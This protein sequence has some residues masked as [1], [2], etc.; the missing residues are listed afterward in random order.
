MLKNSRHLHERPESSVLRNGFS[1]LAEEG[2]SALNSLLKDAREGS[3]T[4][5]RLLELES[6]R[7]IDGVG[8]GIVGG[9]CLRRCVVCYEKLEGM[10]KVVGV[11]AFVEDLCDGREA[12]DSTGRRLSGG[13]DRTLRGHRFVT[14]DR[15]AMRRQS[16]V[17]GV[18][19][20]RVESGDTGAF[21]VVADQGTV[22]A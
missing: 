4:P 12:F 9:K 16:F 5:C 15:V 22:P 1:Q 19:G 21:V 18:P 13:A 10:L 17:A 2:V 20:V 7:V 3:A 11:E 8:V 6:G 14:R